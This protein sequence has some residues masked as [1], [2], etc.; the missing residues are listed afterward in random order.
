MEKSGI[1][2]F[3][4]ARNRFYCKVVQLFYIDLK[5]TVLLCTTPQYFADSYDGLV[6]VFMVYPTLKVQSTDYTPQN[7]TYPIADKVVNDHAMKAYQRQQKYSFVRSE[8]RHWTEVCGQIYTPTIIPPAKE[9]LYQLTH[10]PKCK[11]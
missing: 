9:F 7:L 4:R 5:A 3:S 6:S 2:L 1:Y 10:L 8:P 11:E